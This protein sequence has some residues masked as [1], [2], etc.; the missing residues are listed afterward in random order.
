MSRFKVGDRVRGVKHIRMIP[1]PHL[2]KA[3]ITRVIRPDNLSK[4]E[5]YYLLKWDE[6]KLLGS[7]A[8]PERHLEAV[9]VLE[10]MVEKMDE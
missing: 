4:G 10:Q 7:G 6:D 9:S 8:W 2:C 5:V 1:N 3:T